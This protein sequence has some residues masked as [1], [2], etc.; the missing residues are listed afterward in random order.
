M[1]KEVKLPLKNAFLTIKWD[2][3][4]KVGTITTLN[5]EKIHFFAE[6][7]KSMIR[8]LQRIETEINNYAKT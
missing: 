7:L 2:S 3:K 5:N 1:G 8:E 6:D 4:A